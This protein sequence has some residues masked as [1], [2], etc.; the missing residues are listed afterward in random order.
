MDKDKQSNTSN[1]NSGNQGSSGRESGGNDS[2]KNQTG[3]IKGHT[4]Q[5]LKPVKTKPKAKK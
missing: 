4:V 1:K 2:G 3:F 5:P